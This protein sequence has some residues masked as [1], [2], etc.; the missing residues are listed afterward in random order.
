MYAG[1]KPGGQTNGPG[2]SLTTRL[3][4]IRKGGASAVF[5]KNGASAEIAMVGNEGA[6]GVTLFMEWRRRPFA[7]GTTRWTNNCVA[8]CC[9]RSIVSRPIS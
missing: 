1:L 7:T 9:F 2:A 5:L 6:V 3:P 4:S 8:R